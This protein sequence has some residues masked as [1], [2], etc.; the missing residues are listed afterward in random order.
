MGSHKIRLSRGFEACAPAF[1]RH[2]S[3]LKKFYGKQVI[4][5]LLG[6]KEGE[7]MLSQAYQVSSLTKEYFQAIILNA[8]VSFSILPC[9]NIIL[10]VEKLYICSP[11]AFKYLNFLLI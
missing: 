6:S 10:P 7:H 9:C 3:M 1:D 5:N 2:M 8:A 4:V 11:I